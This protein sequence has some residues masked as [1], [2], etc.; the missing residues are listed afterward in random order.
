[1]AGDPYTDTRVAAFM[2]QKILAQRCPDAIDAHLANVNREAYDS[3]LREDLPQTLTGRA[4]LDAY[5]K[6]NDPVTTVDPAKTY[7]ARAAA[8]HHVR[9]NYRV[10]SFIHLL[11]NSRD[12][13]AIIA[14]GQ[15]MLESHASYRDCAHL[16]HPMTDRLVEM[17][18]AKG[19]AAGFYG[20]KITGGGCGG[21]VAILMRDMEENHAMLQTIRERYTSDTGHP[22]L[23]FV[24]MGPGAAAA[25]TATLK[26]GRT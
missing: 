9:E 23:L 14:A 15:L 6:T 1:V 16:G 13:S 21:T 22:T 17:V 18:M 25:G 12:N 4:F 20:A 10:R 7:H 11:R 2:A 24:G 26:V 3:R 8:D 19:P 5:G